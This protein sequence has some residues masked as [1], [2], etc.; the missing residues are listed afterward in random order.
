MTVIAPTR[1][2]VPVHMRNDVAEAGKVDLVRTEER[3]QG[4][5]DAENGFHQPRL[6]SRIQIRHLSDMT[7]ENYPAKT[8]I[9][10]ISHANDATEIICPKQVAT[11]RAAQFAGLVLRRKIACQL[12]KL[13]SI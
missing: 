7:L 12:I 10:G 5:L 1:N 8:R 13:R 6:L 4:A 2:D 11:G 9:V 3:T